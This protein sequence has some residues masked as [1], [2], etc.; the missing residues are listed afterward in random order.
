M[1]IIVT[2]EHGGNTVPARFRT[3]FNGRERLLNSHRGYDRYALPVAESM[4]VHL[5]SFPR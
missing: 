1:N 5:S 2:C 4:A 3:L